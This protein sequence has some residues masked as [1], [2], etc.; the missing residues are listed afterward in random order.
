MQQNV[1]SPNTFH[2]MKP[3]EVNMVA[4]KRAVAWSKLS[5]NKILEL[6]WFLA[7]NEALIKL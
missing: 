7:V 1:I 2:F 6:V 4:W 5:C 3:A